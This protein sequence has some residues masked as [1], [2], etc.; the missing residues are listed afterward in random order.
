MNFTQSCKFQKIAV[1]FFVIELSNWKKN[2]LSTAQYVRREII[3]I[4]P[5]PRLISD[6]NLEEQV[7]EAL[8]LTGIKVEDKDLYA[9]HRM[10]RRGRVIIKF[11]DRKLRYQVMTN[12]KKLMEKKNELKELHFEES[13]FLSDSIC[14]ENYNLFYKYRLLKNAKKIYACWFFNNGINV[15]LMD[16]S[17]RFKIFHE[18]DLGELLRANVDDLLIW[19]NCYAPM[20]MIY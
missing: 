3:E 11:K 19:E 20:L 8:S 10:K 12:R 16:K 9:C 18:Y 5:V 17:P 14:T 15:R 4:S 2:A 13:L 6:Q 7:C 1:T